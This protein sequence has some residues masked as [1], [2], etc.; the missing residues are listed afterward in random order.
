MLTSKDLSQMF[1]CRECGED[2]ERK[3]AL[4]CKKET[5]REIWETN[6]CY[7]CRGTDPECPHCE[8]SDHIPVCRCPRALSYEISWLLPYFTDWRVSNRVVWPDG[9]SRLF[10]PLKLTEAFDLL[11]QL[12]YEAQDE[13]KST[14]R[15]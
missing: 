6:H 9:G 7:V 14:S 12:V 11:D 3:K 2:D 4:G 15:T 1:D 5:E 8:G 13:S 10:E